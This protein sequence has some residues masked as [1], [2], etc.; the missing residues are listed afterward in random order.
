MMEISNSFLLQTMP[1][2]AVLLGFSTGMLGV[3]IS[4]QRRS[5]EISAL[6][7]GSFAGIL[8]L[9]LFSGF[10]VSISPYF[11]SS[12]GKNIYLFSGSVLG[13]LVMITILNILYKTNRL[14][15]HIIQSI[16]TA[17]LLGAGITL[18]T[19]MRQAGGALDSGIDVYLFGETTSLTD[20]EFYFLKHIAVTVIIL[21]LLFFKRLRVII[22]DKD[23]AKTT[24]F[25]TNFYEHLINVF[26]VCLVTLSVKLMGVFLAVLIFLIPAMTARLWSKRLFTI[27]LLS[28]FFGALGGGIGTFTAGEISHVSTGVSITIALS[29]IFAGSLF[30]APKGLFGILKR[31]GRK[32]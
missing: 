1:K 31:R 26:V 10:A 14:H 17:V 18:T 6:A 13:I 25:H 19:V 22:F 9:S 21:L 16:M 11:L 2:S 29:V 4:Y 7:A 20:E 12:M 24:H 8:L 3:F 5:I 30:I 15:P 32:L 27:T 28:G 23:T